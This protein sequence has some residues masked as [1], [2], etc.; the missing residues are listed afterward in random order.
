LNSFWSVHVGFGFTLEP[1]DAHYLDLAIQKG[2]FTLESRGKEILKLR[3]TKWKLGWPPP[4]RDLALHL[5]IPVEVLDLAH[6][7]WPPN[8]ILTRSQSG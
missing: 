7:E 2:A 5:A 8:E 1:D 3:E 6:V 4:Q